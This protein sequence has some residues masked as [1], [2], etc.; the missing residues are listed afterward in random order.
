M[1]ETNN[2]ITVQKQAEAALQERERRYRTIFQTTGVSI[3]EEDFSRVKAAIDD[4]K[5]QGV[6][7]FRQY[8]ADHPAFI[9]EAIAM[10]KI[11]D[12]NDATVALFGAR[13]RDELLV[14]L[15]KIFVPESLDVFARELLAIA[16]GQTSFQ[17][18]ALAS[19]AYRRICENAELRATFATDSGIR[20][21]WAKPEQEWISLWGPA[22]DLGA[23]VKDRFNPYL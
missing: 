5:M 16:E 22:I 11:I 8:F 14:S 23:K 18:E 20:A 12:V 9:R 21:F 3:W 2:D 1:L 10:V 6:R 19:Y 7:D 13:S 15:H 17:S 4:L